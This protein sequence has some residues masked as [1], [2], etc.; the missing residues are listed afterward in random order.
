MM[1]AAGSYELWTGR[2][3]PVDVMRESID[4]ER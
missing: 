2:R 4:G 1:Q 3:A